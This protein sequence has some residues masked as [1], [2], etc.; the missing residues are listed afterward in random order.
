MYFMFYAA[1]LILSRLMRGEL[2]S[3]KYDTMRAVKR[4]NNRLPTFHWSN[5]LRRGSLS[6][7]SE[8]FVAIFQQN[9]YNDDTHASVNNLM[10]W[11]IKFSV[12]TKTLFY[13]VRR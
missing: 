1:T 9:C 6:D 10:I 5:C 8:A 11:L 3:R 13:A 12:E 2:R 4:E 7:L